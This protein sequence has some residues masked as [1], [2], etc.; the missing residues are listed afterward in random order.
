[1]KVFA[2]AAAAMW[3][4]ENGISSCEYALLMAFVASAIIVSAWALASSVEGSMIGAAECV[5]GT[6]EC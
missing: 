4:D 3:A 1:M 2:K 5:K 6:V